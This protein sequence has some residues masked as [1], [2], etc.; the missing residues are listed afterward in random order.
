MKKFIISIL[1]LTFATCVQG[2]VDS[3]AVRKCIQNPDIFDGQVVYKSADKMPEYIGGIA[4]FNKYIHQHLKFSSDVDPYKSKIYTTFI[5]DTLGRVQNVCT[6]N[7]KT[8]TAQEKELVEIIQNS[9][10]WTPGRHN[11]KNVCVRL[12]V[13]MR[14]CLK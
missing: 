3:F 6:I 7:A 14:I 9:P 4:A 5:I 11:G 12:T 2:Q 13:P 10:P 8:Q 1:S